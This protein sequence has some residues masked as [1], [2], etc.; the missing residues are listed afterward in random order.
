[1]P[2]PLRLAFFFE[3][4]WAG[5]QA[6]VSEPVR[7][8]SKEGVAVDFFCPPSATYTPPSLGKGVRVLH[9]W[10]RARSWGFIRELQSDAVHR[11]YD[12][13]LGAPAESLVCAAL[14]ARASRV[15]LIAFAEE[16]LTKDDRRQ[17]SP[18]L[19]RL[20]NW[21]Y[22]QTQLVVVP[23]LAWAEPLRTS[24]GLSEDH[25]FIELPNAPA[26]EALG[27]SRAD[28]RA[29]LGI[30]EDALVALYMGTLQDRW[31]GER[32]LDV[33]PLLPENAYLLFQLSRRQGTT[34]R[35]LA[36]IAESAH[37]ARFVL[38]PWPYDEI[39]R[40]VACADIGIALYADRTPNDRMCGKGSGKAGR[41]LRFGLPM[42]VSR[43]GGLTWLADRGASEVAD[44]APQIA[45]AIGRIGE[46]YGRYSERAR[47][48]YREEFAFERYF[49]PVREAILEAALGRRRH[50]RWRQPEG[51]PEAGE[52]IR[53]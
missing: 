41:Y 17:L 27:F 12:L 9:R 5:T 26:G 2:P 44:T 20:M 29:R 47:A 24:V 6:F 36:R 10:T 49:P 43:S 22:S 11:P 31:G 1:M 40:G 16:I 30:P 48:C 33:L 38:D 14:V 25:R 45:D 37:R 50:A 13:V 52:A 21:A 34:F 53:S 32:L 46:S 7:A 8:L 28:E 23:D 3:N 39:D 4:E 42:I 15:P 35:W 51:A 18:R 19:R